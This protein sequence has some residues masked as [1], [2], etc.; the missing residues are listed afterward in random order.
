MSINQYQVESPVR[1]NVDGLD[2][3][4]E[5]QLFIVFIAWIGG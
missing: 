2:V 3:R 5:I 1:V 4:F